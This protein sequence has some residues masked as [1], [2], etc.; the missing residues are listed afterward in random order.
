VTSDDAQDPGAD[1]GPTDTRSALQA[2]GDV[3]G[4]RLCDLSEAREAA[5]EGRPAEALA[6]LARALRDMAATGSLAGLD[7]AAAEG[8]ALARDAGDDP[9]E[10]RLGDLVATAGR[11]DLLAS[12]LAG[13]W[14]QSDQCLAAGDAP[15]A[16]ARARAAL[17]LAVR[18]GDARAAAVAL[19]VLASCHESEG[20]LDAVALCLQQAARTLGL[21]GPDPDAPGLLGAAEAAWRA[22]GREDEAAGARDERL[23]AAE[24]AGDAAAVVDLLCEGA[25][26]ALARHDAREAQRLARRALAAADGADPGAEARAWR[27]L[28][29]VLGAAG[30]GEGARAA[31][32][33]ADLLEGAFP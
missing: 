1:G 16:V 33:R 11:E 15:G 26:G 25:D 23:R 3:L 22:A 6:A 31:D 14:Q 5:R 27:T 13:L 10:E 21:S 12:V 19:A 2:R 30:D 18:A 9:L 4:V 28:G 20:R 32:A 17:D 29:R 8:L 24:A 7:V